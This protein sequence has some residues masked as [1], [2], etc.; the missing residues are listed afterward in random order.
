MHINPPA[1][2]T[3]SVLGEPEVCGQCQSVSR[4]TNGLCLN[5]LLRAALAEE[6][7]PSDKEAFKEVLDSVKPRGG[8]WHI[9]DHEILHEIARGGMGVVYQARAPHSGRLVA[10]KCVLA[11][12]NDDHLVARFRREAETAARLEHP[13]IVPIYQVGETAEGSPY[14]TMKYAAAGSLLQARRPLLE[15]PRQSVA[16]M[17]KVA[18]AVHYAHENGVLHR[19]LKPGNILLDSHGEPLVSDFGLARCEAVSSYL[20]RSLTSFGTPGYIAPEQADGPAAN[21]TAAADVYSLGA[22]LFELLT[23]RTPFVGD[24][25]FAVMKQSA[26]E[27]APK[28]RSLASHVDRDLE[29][30]CDRCL[31]RDPAD[32]YQSAAELADDLQSWLDDR[33]IRAR[34]PSALLHARRWV[35]RNRTLAA[36]LAVLVLVAGASILWL[37]RAQRIQAAMAE[38][39][40]AARSVVILPFID[41]DAVAE[42]HGTTEWVENELRRQFEKLGPGRIVS[43]TALPWGSAEEIQNAAQQGKGRTVMTG[44]VRSVNEKRRISLRLLDPTKGKILFGVLLEQGGEGNSPRADGEWAREIYRLVSTA[45]WGPVISSRIDPGLRNPDAADDIAAGQNWIR[46]YT[47]DGVDHA[48]TKFKQ[49]IVKQPDSAIAHA[50]LAIAATGRTHYRADPEYFEIGKKEAREALRLDPFSVDAHRALSGVYFQDG[51]FQEALE[52][53]LKTIEIDGITNGSVCVGVGTSYDM[54]GR[55]DRALGW[56]RLG[57]ELVRQPGIVEPQIGDSWTRLGNDEAAFA[58]YERAVELQPGSLRGSVG[59]AHLHLLRGEFD[60]AREIC[61]NQ[62][63]NQN[64]LGYMLQVAAQIEFFDRKFS[65]AQELYEK[66]AKSDSY[67]GGSFYGAITYQSALGRIKQ[68]LND[69]TGGAALLRDSLERETANLNRQPSNPEAA[70]RVAAVEASLNLSEAAFR[71]LNQAVNLGWLDY[72]SLQRDPRFDALRDNPELS[73]LID[74]LSA[75]VAELRSKTKGINEKVRH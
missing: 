20:T 3:F 45:D 29:I 47:I 39:I 2:S 6:D 36:A 69:P 30:I 21:L 1:Q 16:M 46:A 4:L 60:L 7:T 48:I 27:R 43:G 50:W 26:Q 28:L 74:G 57:S 18:R 72:R 40:V 14:Y 33:P 23:G 17:V 41:L 68:E 32:R 55:P 5:C 44:T 66:L 75:K 12:R 24:N 58:V 8:D 11:Y 53:Q 61:F 49:A 38:S 67:G 42:D 37:I 71:H 59:K 10:L 31:E 51:K 54:L 22:I 65:A 52:E 19:D 9:A 70:Y 64:E 35:R 15:H 56:F 13:N 63:R 34:P 62:I 73:T 25:A